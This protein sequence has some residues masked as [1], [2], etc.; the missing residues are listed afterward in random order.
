LSPVF[1]GG[2]VVS[3]GVDGAGSALGVAGAGVVA[4][5][6]AGVVGA[7]RVVTGPV[8]SGRYSGPLSPQPVEASAKVS[9][10]ATLADLMV[11]WPRP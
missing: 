1:G 8:F 3:V 4:D 11:D 9:I 2:S 7:G 5:P 10:A 6:V